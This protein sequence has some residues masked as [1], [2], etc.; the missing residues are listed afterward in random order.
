MSR[1]QVIVFGQNANQISHA[2]RYTDALGLGRAAVVA[3][4]LADLRPHLPLAHPPPLN[5]PHIGIIVVDGV[6]LTYHAYPISM[7]L[8]NVGAIIRR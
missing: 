3:A 7:D 8:V 6:S 4:I 2:F 1:G 5:A